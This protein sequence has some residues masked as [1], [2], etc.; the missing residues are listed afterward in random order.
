MYEERGYK[1]QARAYQSSAAAL[2]YAWAVGGIKTLGRSGSAE[3]T[4]FSWAPRCK[5]QKQ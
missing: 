1:A 3:I 5:N 4:S 2:R